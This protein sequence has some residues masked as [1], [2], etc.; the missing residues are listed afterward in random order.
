MRNLICGVGINDA[1][2]AVHRSE[3]IGGKR[4]HVWRCPYYRVWSCMLQ[5]CYNQKFLKRQ[6]AYAG[7]KAAPE[8]HRFSVFKSWMERQ[9]WEGRQLDK[10]ILRNGSKLY[11]PD[12]CAF[13][14][15]E[16]NMFL[17]D[18][19]LHRGKYPIGARWHP[20]SKRFAASCSNP[21]T[22]LRE[23]LGTFESPEAAH[24]AWRKRKH[25]L[26]CRYA[27]TQKD[28][29]VRAAMRA[30]YLPGSYYMKSL[31]A[32]EAPRKYLTS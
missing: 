26:A 22:G 32:P 25:E 10:D 31:E 20:A 11:S 12:T 1:G 7:C 18:R 16:L 14:S 24:E 13:V 3:V 2:Y 23:D 17:V 30:R 4:R 29:R 19:E 6:P 27:D 8:W 21:F 15:R 5:R 9:D 28:P